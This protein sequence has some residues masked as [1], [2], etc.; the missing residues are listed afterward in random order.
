MIEVQRTDN[1][2]MSNPAFSSELRLREVT[3]DDVEEILFHRRQMF[4]DMGHVDAAVLEAIVRSSRPFVERSLRD[5]GYHGWFAVTAAGRVAAGAGLLIIPW[6]SGPLAPDQAYRAYL[7]NV[8]T[9]PEFRRRGLAR[10]LTA[11]VIDY[12]RERGYKLL[13][14]HASKYGQSLYESLGFEATN[15]MKLTL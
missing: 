14:L 5:G 11:K 2:P 13:W 8:Y 10:R 12:C 4:H 3:S 6:V 9:Y 1:S 15:E 7:L